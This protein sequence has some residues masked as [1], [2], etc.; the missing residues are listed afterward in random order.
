MPEYDS[1]TSF[2]KSGLNRL[3]DAEHLLTT[4]EVDIHEQGVLSRHMRGAMYLSGYG[5]ECQLK[6]YLISQH[7]PYES[8][9]DVL[10]ELRKKDPTIR[11][12]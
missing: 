6:A 11:D 4:P 3:R 10:I 12:I 1:L 9:S 8:L 7:P 2:H 5:V